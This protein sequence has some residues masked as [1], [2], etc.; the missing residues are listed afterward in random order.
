MFECQ[1]QECLFVLIQ[2]L[3][4]C[5]KSVTEQNSVDLKFIHI[6]FRLHFPAHY[7][8]FSLKYQFTAPVIH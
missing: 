7:F 5:K 8:L 2:N 6:E 4:V 1:I 3:R